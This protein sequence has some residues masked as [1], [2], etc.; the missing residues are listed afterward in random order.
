ME[1]FER[2]VI[3]SEIYNSYFPINTLKTELDEHNKD[4]IDFKELYKLSS[5]SKNFSIK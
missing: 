1:N 4:D 5:T 2:N 3:G